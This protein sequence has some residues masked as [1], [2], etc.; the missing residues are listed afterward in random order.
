MTVSSEGTVRLTI[1]LCEISL[2][3]R[4]KHSAFARF[5]VGGYSPWPQ[6]YIERIDA[7]RRPKG[8]LTDPM[9]FGMAGGAQW[10]GI[11]IAR[12][13]SDTT[14]GSGLHMRGF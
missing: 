14:I 2:L 8:Q 11:T 1:W 10:N 7:Q 5:Y 13:H 9:L 3:A 6:S 4:P 12:L